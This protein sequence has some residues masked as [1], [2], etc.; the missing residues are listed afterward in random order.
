VVLEGGSIDVNG[1]GLLLTTEQ[2]LLGRVQVRNPGIPRKLIEHSLKVSLGVKKVLWLSGGIAGDDTNG[3]IDGVARFVAANV[4]VAAVE[5]DPNDTN[6]QPLDRNYKLLKSMRDTN[7]KPLRIVPIPMPRPVRF[8]DQRLPASYLNFYIT[9]RSV[10]VP[11]FND[12][13][14]RVALTQLERL[15]PSREVIGIHAGDLVLGLGTLHC[16]TQQ[17]PA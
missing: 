1:Q 12:P 10:L 15:F 7:G 5:H 3:H 14:D 8:D 11:T 17:E 6:Y 9:N 4:V 2:C 13:N 16:L